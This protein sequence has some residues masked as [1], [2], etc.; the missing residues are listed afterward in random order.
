MASVSVAARDSLRVTTDSWVRSHARSVAV[1]S[2][3]LPPTRTRLTPRGAYSF[4]N[5]RR[6]ACTSMPAGRRPAKAFSSSGASAA[7]NSASRMRSSSARSGAVSSLSPIITRISA[8][9]AIGSVSL[10]PIPRF[11]GRACRDDVTARR[12]LFTK[13]K[14][15]ESALLM[16]FEAP[17]A[18][19]FKHRGK[20][21]RQHRRDH[22][23]FDQIGDEILVER[24]P[25]ERLADQALQRL[26]RLGKRPD[27]AFGQPHE[28]SRFGLPPAGI[29]RQQVIERRR[30][31]RMPDLGD[32][33]GLTAGKY[34][35]AE[36]R[37]IEQ[38]LGD[39]A[40]RLEP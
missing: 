14:R 16:R 13:I 24:A 17:F 36:L 25:V 38:L 26:A 34:L 40:D 27:R 4:C 33:L 10:L 1:R 2:V 23:R 30:P 21:R 5:C 12:W 39:L 18:H 7:N 22:R 32:R 35:A 19:Q 29:S 28:R 8:T 37:P 9:F 20:A 3:H 31:L 6:S 15:R 11:R